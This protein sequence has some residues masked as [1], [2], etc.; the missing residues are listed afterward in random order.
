MQASNN[1]VNQKGQLKSLAVVNTPPAKAGGFGLR[2]KAGLIG[3]T[4]DCPLSQDWER[5]RVRV[6]ISTSEHAHPSPRPSPLKGRGCKS[7]DAA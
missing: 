7:N 1:R 2:L 6:Q 3:H 4:A 5:V